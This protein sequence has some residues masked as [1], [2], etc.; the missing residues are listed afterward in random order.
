MSEHSEQAALFDWAAWQV[1][2]GYEPL[3][4]MYAVPNG[5]HRHKATAGRLK[6][7][8]VKAGVPDICL[9]F[10]ARGYHGLYIEMK[11]GKNKAT[12]EQV[13]YLEWLTGCGY[14][15]L[16]ANGFDEARAIL[17]DYLEDWKQ[18]SI[19][20]IENYEIA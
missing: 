6:A 3:R 8:G 1:N 19:E 10:P 16:V 15:A 14:L 12:P 4:W 11:A 13:D 2:L 17:C 9:P 20:R 7:E 5:G 18:E